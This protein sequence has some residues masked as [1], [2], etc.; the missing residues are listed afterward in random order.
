MPERTISLFDSAPAAPC[1]APFN[2]AGYVLNHAADLGDK[3]AV[4][5]VGGARPSVLGY[6][7]LRAA[8]LGT[9]TGLLQAGFAPGDRVLLRLGNSLDMPLAYLGCIA[10]G[11]VPV[12][13]SASVR[14]AEVS[15]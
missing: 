7:D 6:A 9:A 12:L 10:A 3:P 15:T 11:L 4:I 14:A 2:M 8:V 13:T 5:V 1:P